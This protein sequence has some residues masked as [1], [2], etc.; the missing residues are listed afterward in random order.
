MT[1]KFTSFFF[2]YISVFGLVLSCE[3][4]DL[5]PI[6]LK[7]NTGILEDV[8]VIDG[9][10]HFKDY[11]VVEDFH[12]SIIALSDTERDA[13][14]ESIGF[15]SYRKVF[16]ISADEFFELKSDEE[17]ED[18]K[19]K[20]EDILYIDEATQTVIPRMP[21]F[22]YEIIGN[23]A[24]EYMVGKKYVKVLHDKIIR[25]LDG[26]KEKLPIAQTLEKSSEE[27]DIDIAMFFNESLDITRNSHECGVKKATASYTRNDNKR[28][29][30]LKVN[31]LNVPTGP[32]WYAQSTQIIVEVY[33]H[34][35]GLF[36][37]WNKYKTKLAFDN[38]EAKIRNYEGTVFTVS[39]IDSTKTSKSRELLW[40][41]E[42]FGEGFNANFP[43]FQ[44]PEIIQVKGR[45]I[46]NGVLADGKWAVLCC[47][48]LENDCPNATSA[49]LDPF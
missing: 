41:S 16:N 27:L 48:Y 43:G 40:K 44:D 21:S 25:I 42:Y 3:A 30:F 18:W 2:S 5:Q 13:L 4:T 11:S 24:G 15:E 20:Y 22:Y 29:V 17:L 19:L 33:G 45:A 36:G 35:K 9:V 12:N 26:D 37:G 1:H 7:H 39:N 23:R 49:P 14:E 6:K 32:I 31:V 28:R 34:K 8:D 46:S 38:L 47:N 10:L